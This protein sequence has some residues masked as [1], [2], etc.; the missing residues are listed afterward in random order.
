MSVAVVIPYRAGCPHREAA[1]QWTEVQFGRYMRRKIILGD[2]DPDQ[3]FNRAEAII[4]GA[5]KTDADVL[6]VSDADCW[7][8]GLDEAL[9]AIER[10]AAWAIPHSKL[11]RLNEASTRRVLDGDEPARGMKLEQSPY[12]G[13]EAGTLLVIRRNVLLEVPPDQR[14]VG[15]GH[16]EQAWSHALTT[17]VSPPWRATSESLWHLWHPPQQRKSRSSGSDENK[18]LLQRYKA[19][20][21]KPAAMRALVHEAKE[22]MRCQSIAS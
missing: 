13:Y 5:R 15:W 22:A 16:E 17:L 14:F 10:G 11:R 4:D 9:G 6:I 21:L 7:T 2:C 8:W 20:R 18:A 3:P 19:A 1:L 12:T